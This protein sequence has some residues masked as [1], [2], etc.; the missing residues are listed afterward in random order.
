MPELRIPPRTA[1]ADAAYKA[2]YDCGLNGA[3]TTNCHFSLFA[4]I[5]LMKAWSDGKEDGEKDKEASHARPK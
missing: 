3:N 2:G 1:S 4:T 5:E